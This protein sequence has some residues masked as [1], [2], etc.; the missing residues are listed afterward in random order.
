MQQADDDN[1]LE[2]E[3]EGEKKQETPLKE[4]FRDPADG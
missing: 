1:D 3:K 2:G 4:F